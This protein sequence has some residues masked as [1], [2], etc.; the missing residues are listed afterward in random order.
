MNKEYMD[1][2][3]TTEFKEHLLELFKNMMA[4]RYS[5]DLIEIVGNLLRTFDK[6]NKAKAVIEFNKIA[7]KQLPE[8]EFHLEISKKYKELQGL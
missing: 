1:I 8:Q 2:M 3:T 4:Q 5:I 7:Q 6:E